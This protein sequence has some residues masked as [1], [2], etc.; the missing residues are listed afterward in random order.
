M[1]CIA[2]PVGPLDYPADGPE[3]D[4]TLG[5]LEEVSPGSV[6]ELALASAD[7]RAG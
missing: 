7:R 5:S 3:A 6:E 4:L 1:T 2:I